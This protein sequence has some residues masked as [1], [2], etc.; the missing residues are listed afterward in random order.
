MYLQA[1][2]YEKLITIALSDDLLPH[3]NPIDAR[4]IRVYRLQFAFR[5][6]LKADRVSDAV[7][8]AMRAG[9]EVAGDER[10]N[11]LLR[12]NLDLLIHV[13]SREKVREIAFKR[14]LSSSWT[15]SENIYSAALLSGFPEYQGEARGYLRASLN[16]LSIYFEGSKNGDEQDHEE[17]LQD[18][19][20]LQIALAKLRLDGAKAC[21]SFLNHL[22]PKE[23]V[24]RIVG[25]LARNLIGQGYFDVLEQL[26]KLWKNNV[27][28]VIAITAELFQIGHVP[29]TGLI[30]ACLSKLTNPKARIRIPDNINRPMRAELLTFLECC[31]YRNLSQADVLFVLGHYF[32]VRA[33]RM[34]TDD[35]S[36][37]ARTLFMRS[38]AIRC[39][40]KG[41]ES[42]SMD[43]IM[44]DEV[45]KEK[46]SYEQN[47][48]KT[49]FIQIIEGL[50]P[51]YM[52][53]VQVLASA[54]Q[55]I[56]ED[57]EKAD[58]KSKKAL[59]G[60]YKGY[61][62]LPH[63]IAQLK[64]DLLIFAR[65][66]TTSQIEEFFSA[67]LQQSKSLKLGDW[68]LAVSASYRLT[69]LQP[70]SGGLERY[71]YELIKKLG[72]KGPE[73]LAERYINLARAVLVNSK[74]DASV[75]FDDAIGIVSK[76]G[77][78]LRC[79]WEAIVGLATRSCEGKSENWDELSYR[80]IRV[81]EVVGEQKREKHWS[82][83]EAVQL[84][85]RLSTTGGI[86]AVSRWRDRDVGR[87]EWMQADLIM[88]L[89]RQ[90]PQQALLFWSMVSFLHLEPLKFLIADF[91]AITGVSDSD[92]EVIFKDTVARFR[93]E[94]TSASY[95][96]D[97]AKLGKANGLKCS[98]LDKVTACL[99]VNTAKQEDK[100]ADTFDFGTVVP[101][102]DIM[103]DED[104]L[105]P[106]GLSKAKSRF[107][108]YA[109][110]R[111]EHYGRA[112]FLQ[113]AIGELKADQLLGFIAAMEL[114]DSIEYYDFQTLFEL[115]PLPWLNT[116]S[117]KR[118]YLRVVKGLGRKYCEKLTSYWS[119]DYFLK[120]L[121]SHPNNAQA[122]SEG[123]LEGFAS[124][125]EFAVAEV[126]FGFA[127]TASASIP[128]S[129][130]KAV[131]DYSLG[132]FELH[133]DE[134]YGD[135]QWGD[136]LRT[137]TELSQGVAG[138]L[139][140]A[141][142]SPCRETRWRACHC[143]VRMADFGNGQLIRNLFSWLEMGQ[144]GAFGSKNFPFYNLHASQYLF[145][146]IFRISASDPGQLKEYSA[147]FIEYGLKQQHLIIQI[148]AAGAAK[149]IEAS[150]P[151]TYSADTLTELN[152]IGIP[153]GERQEKYGFTTDS[154]LHALGQLPTDIDFHFGY[155]FDRYWFAPL[156]RI[157][158][159]SETQVQDLV[160]DVVVNQWGITEGG[161]N[162][163]PRVAIWNRNS[164]SESTHY[165]K[166]SFPRADNLD[167]YH[168][169]H[170]MMV[171]GSALI[172]HMPVISSSDWNDERWENWLA[173]QFL[174]FRNGTWL[175]DQRDSL[176]L[177]RPQWVSDVLS[178]E[179]EDKL[180]DQDYLDSIV[181]ERDGERW[182][183]V[184]GWWS[185]RKDSFTESYSISSALVS[186][187][188]ADSLFNA[189]DTCGDTHD[190]KLP[191]YL[192]EDMEVDSAPFKLRGWLY[193]S[194]ITKGLDGFDP[195]A[196]ELLFPPISIGPQIIQELGIEAYGD[197]KMYR[198]SDNDEV[199]AM[200]Q[201]WVSEIIDRNDQADQSGQ[202]FSCNLGFIQLICRTYGAN[203]ILKV[204]LDRSYYSKYGGASDHSGYKP[205]KHKM[206]L[207]NENGEVN[208]ARSSS[209]TGPAAGQ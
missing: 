32:P 83:G 82:R 47:Q 33:E 200:A 81:A 172:K 77:E 177:K 4:N 94:N 207:I 73:E 8:L 72:D 58:T 6:A 128:V 42:P 79:R 53:K 141:L 164:R 3:D 106:V 112:P 131:L 21:T 59:S 18:G 46:S 149:N 199:L 110:E 71:A 16:W 93:K 155:D 159:V 55:L 24:F 124:G 48:K 56:L 89:A 17:L 113:W 152:G 161:Y 62:A 170:G 9:E 78:E 28:C 30:S 136:W 206:F 96:H 22:N 117:F 116:A 205:A 176:P 137:D 154:Y 194:E 50:L 7:K 85:A 52:L 208:Y 57:I 191:S 64:L 103:G 12:A 15:G 187:D 105:S 91:L 197:G 209:E 148:A 101:W 120:S 108:H 35:H 68:L 175:S 195:F 201:S 54:G 66:L 87:F 181:H 95:W 183:N 92:K 41:I 168:S 74:Q 88:E 14:I 156:G 114:C 146:A 104:L 163:D 86:A 100:V 37:T 67:H 45:K 151:G 31:I 99:S 126:F 193:Q 189:L 145:I 61:D 115:L 160:A 157:F 143:I 40:L 192:E 122:L 107:E 144:V 166:T 202:R 11:G 43:E 121:P 69:H 39:F 51:W 80:F 13:Q 196:E 76:F 130:A 97:L 162:N 186:S 75:Y 38:L 165:S 34:V 36:S 2:Q 98:E 190:F 125:T 167:F 25:D 44:G 65:Q 140:S 27:H 203:L 10:Q 102:A 49:D 184:K 60:R 185:E 84:A 118:G 153:V 180:S 29:Q 142:G 138:Y 198:V 147:L 171:V 174:T 111:N 158:G 129:E 5:S 139:W 123:I 133:L 20:V 132:R 70:L 19:D 188:T 173:S 63:E 178:R 127:R 119:F 1:G 182:I 169:Y 26:L 109:Q 150:F 23:A 204:Q 179:W 135:G 134:D 90:Q